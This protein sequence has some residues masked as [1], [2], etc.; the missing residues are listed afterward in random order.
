MERDNSGKVTKVIYTTRVID[1]EKKQEEK[2]IRKAQ[3]D[4]LTGLLNR[5]AYEDDISFHRDIPEEDDFMYISIDVNGLKAINDTLGHVAGDELLV[6]ASLCMKRSLGSYGKVYRT[7]GDEFVAILFCDEQKLKEVL[8]DFDDMVA[9]WSGKLVDNISVSYGWISKYEKVGASF[10]ELGNI[11]DQRMY[12]AKAAYYQKSGVDRRGQQEAHKAL[13]ALYTKI[14][15]VNLS[16]DS[17]QIIDMKVEEKT[18]ERGFST[19]ISKWL[20]LFGKTGQVHPE[21]LAEYLEKTDI[22]YINDYFSQGK[23]S[24]HI[25]YRRKYGDS[26]KQ[27]MMEMIP[28][29]DYSENNHSFFLYVKEI[30]K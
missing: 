5:R 18:P 24:L 4:E 15:K 20:E 22:S 30:D 2:L 7:G 27:V 19:K 16:E 13:C 26:F 6:G 11:A 28:A 17:Y 29:G 1:E 23:N 8:A 14:L 10:R 25:F 21:D 3:T 12:Q 9:K